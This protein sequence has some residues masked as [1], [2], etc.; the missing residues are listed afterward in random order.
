MS[1]QS[2]CRPRWRHASARDADRKKHI[3]RLK[4]VRS[5]DGA[6]RRGRTAFAGSPDGGKGL[7]MRDG[8]AARA[9]WQISFFIALALTALPARAA[10]LDDNDT[11]RLAGINEAIKS[12]EDDVS[13][14]LHDLPPDDA[15]QIE[16]YSYVELNLEAAHERLN[17]IFVLV[18]I[19]TYVES[20]SDQLLILSVMH[21]QLLRQSRN[22]LGEK[23]DAIA[24]MAAA[25]PANEV[26]A[27]YRTRA[28][29]ILGDRAIPL[30][31]ELYRKTDDLQ[32]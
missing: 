1:G 22:Y 21:A 5:A 14:A 31:D 20:S 19:S 3:V 18:A 12:F 11:S 26:F 28:T 13:S 17:T 29:A 8:I 9:F 23:E 15:E 4:A 2:G 25:H 24:S 10:V 6:R 7:E 27:A 30:L 32:R 16:A